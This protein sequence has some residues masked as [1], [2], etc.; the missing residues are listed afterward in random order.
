MTFKQV[1]NFHLLFKKLALSPV[2]KLKSDGI[3]KKE[4][5]NK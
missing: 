2:P 5:V 3:I 4:N 1:L